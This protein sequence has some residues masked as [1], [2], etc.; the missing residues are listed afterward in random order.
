MGQSTGHHIVQNTHAF[1][2]GD[3]LKRPR[4]PLLCNLIG[5]HLWALHTLVQ[6]LPILR[7][8][9]PGDDIQHRRFASTIG[10]NDGTH[11]AFT[12]VKGDI[13]DRLNTPK[14]KGNILHLHNN[15]TDLATVGCHVSISLIKH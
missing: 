2:Q 8:V 12:N 7:D 1:K 15:W 5:T 13:L 3:V 4:D 6:N 11:F 14:P 9:K 10:T